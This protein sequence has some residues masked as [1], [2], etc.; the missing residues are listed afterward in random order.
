MSKK[1]TSTAVASSS[2]AEI[3]KNDKRWNFRGIP[4]QL[5]EYF[6]KASYIGDDD[7]GNPV[8]YL[9][10]ML[11]PQLASW[12]VNKINDK[13]FR[14]RSHNDT[15]AYAKDME[16]GNW[17]LAPEP[18]VISPNGTALLDGQHRLKACADSGIPIRIGITFGD[19]DDTIINCGK[20]RSLSDL[21]NSE[22]KF[23]TEMAGALQ[24]IWAHFTGTVHRNNKGTQGS[25]KLIK[26]IFPYFGQNV[27][28]YVKRV[29]NCQHRGRIGSVAKVSGL[30]AIFSMIDADVADKLF[31]YVYRKNGVS[32]PKNIENLVQVMV[33]GNMAKSGEGKYLNYRQ[34]SSALVSAWNHIYAGHPIPKKPKIKKTSQHY[35]II[36]GM[37]E[38]ALDL[39]FSDDDDQ[40]R[41]ICNMIGTGFL[42]D[43]YIKV[44]THIEAQIEASGGAV[45]LS[46]SDIAKECGID[47]E[48]VE[49]ILD[50]F[51]ERKMFYM[52]YGKNM[53]YFYICEEAPSVV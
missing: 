17:V 8:Y 21:L 38:L 50:E 3:K 53:S 52:N 20:G 5:K 49:L 34:L 29:I 9:I 41:A 48:E 4:K 40:K 51:C 25:R 18:I 24:Q 33:E 32:V 14:K 47:R 37:R 6:D 7:N 22:T 23:N 28:H 11:C 13:N 31:T 30:F 15:V 39:A 36:V 42:F 27:E 46:H 35:P 19:Y 16:T 2:G 26:S 44:S 1:V 43:K 45:K 12:I 10:V